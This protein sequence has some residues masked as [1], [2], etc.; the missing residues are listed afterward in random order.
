MIEIIKVF[1]AMAVVI[2]ICFLPIAFFYGLYI[3][4]QV[5]VEYKKAATEYLRNSSRDHMVDLSKGRVYVLPN[6]PLP[7][8]DVTEKGR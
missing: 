2:F 5:S 4:F 6:N 8:E 1:L 7:R 3:D